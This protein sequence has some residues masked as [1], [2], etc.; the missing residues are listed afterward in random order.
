MVAAG[1]YKILVVDDEQDI[2]DILEYN[3]KNEGYDV[4]CSSD[5]EQGLKIAKEWQPNLVILDIMMPKMDGV[6][7][8]RRLRQ[9]Q[10]CRSIYVL[11]LT[12]RQEEYTEL[13]AFDAG[14]DGF[15]HKPVKPRALLSRI[16][17]IF[18]RNL[19][20]ETDDNLPLKIADLEIV[21]DEFLVYQNG[22]PI[23]LPKKE[24]ELLHFLASRPGKV[25]SREVLLEK[26]WGN[27][28]YV[29]QRTIDVHIRKLREK[30]GEQYIQTVK[31]VGYKFMG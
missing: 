8:C 7:V 21:K 19:E 12:A 27:D 18:R 11:F 13:A 15:I 14:G 5:G 31:G 1:K 20:L 24:F 3:F 17:A 26:I 4:K 25:F 16:K 10:E 23:A 22:H 29:V 30:L 28:V 9:I 6:E 2:L